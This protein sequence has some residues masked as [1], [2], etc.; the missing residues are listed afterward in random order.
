MKKTKKTMLIAAALTAAAGLAGCTDEPKN[1]QN[2][3]GPPNDYS[4]DMRR[5]E[6]PASV[7]ESRGEESD[8]YDPDEEEVAHVYG[9]PADYSESEDLEDSSESPEEGEDS[10]DPR[11]DRIPVVYGPPN[12]YPQD[13]SGEEDPAAVIESMG[14]ESSDHDHDEEEI[15]DVDDPPA[16][17]DEDGLEIPKEDNYDP[18]LDEITVV[19]GPP[20]DLG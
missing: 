14:E 19:Y 3:Y 1:V 2:V 10:Y 15:E 11:L 18:Y 6:D 20:E 8:P 5:E 17:Y 16:D 12:D 7:E 9:P 4:Q 13:L